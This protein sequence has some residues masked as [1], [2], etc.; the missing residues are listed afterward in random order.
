MQ[1]R[2]VFREAEVT[3]YP[4]YAGKKYLGVEY[5][6]MPLRYDLVPEK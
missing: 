6:A 4:V 2:R 5:R 1:G 3:E